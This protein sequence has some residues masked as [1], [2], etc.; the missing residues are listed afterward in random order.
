[1][2]IRPEGPEEFWCLG[3]RE[4]HRMTFDPVTRFVWEGDVGQEHREEIN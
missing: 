4:P 3:L 1:L 2:S